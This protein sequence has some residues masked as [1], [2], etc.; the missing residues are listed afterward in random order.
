MRQ[1]GI[2]SRGAYYYLDT[3]EDAYIGFEGN[4]AYDIYSGEDVV[5]VWR[6]DDNSGL[7]KDISGDVKDAL[8]AIFGNS[9]QIPPA[10][11]VPDQIRTTVA[12]TPRQ[13]VFQPMPSSG[14]GL[15]GGD[16]SIKAE[17]ALLIAG[18]FIL[19]TFGKRSR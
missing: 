8:I 4:S 13:P 14:G 3:G 12:V 9:N 15:F 10:R 18:A 17:Y 5:L 19:F 2:D 11:Q 6:D 16:I 7:I 1:V